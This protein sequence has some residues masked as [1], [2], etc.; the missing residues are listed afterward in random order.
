MP[1]IPSLILQLQQKA[2]SLLNQPIRRGRGVGQESPPTTAID[3]IE[4][5]VPSE[6]ASVLK[7]GS[8]SLA[9]EK[10][11]P[12]ASTEIPIETHAEAPADAPKSQNE[13]EDPPYGRK[14]CAS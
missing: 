12:T 7:E 10:E 5:D 3:V 13:K 2:V 4:G 14:S 6:E 11:P 8:A 1:R 9:S